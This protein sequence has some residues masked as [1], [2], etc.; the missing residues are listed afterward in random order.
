MSMQPAKIPGLVLP[1]G[2]D[3]V[4]DDRTF[5]PATCDRNLPISLRPALLADVARVEAC[6]AEMID[7]LREDD[8]RMDLALDLRQTPNTFSD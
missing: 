8:E 5:V 6:G 3:I 1:G 4:A 2:D 7:A